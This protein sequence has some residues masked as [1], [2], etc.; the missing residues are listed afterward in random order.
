MFVAQ[1]SF[2]KQRTD[3]RVGALVRGVNAG[4]QDSEWSFEIDDAGVGRGCQQV[5]AFRIFDGAAADGEDHLAGLRQNIREVAG[6]CGAE[7]RLAVVGE[8]VGDGLAGFGGDVVVE[9]DEGPAEQSRERQ[10]VGLA[11]A[12]GST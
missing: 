9:V 2:G 6:F 7:V 5:V 10:A 3:W 4:Q 8:D 12:V 11:R 1:C